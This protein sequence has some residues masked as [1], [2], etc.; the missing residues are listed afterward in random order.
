MF[1]LKATA[2]FQLLFIYIKIT[3]YAITK[4]LFKKSITWAIS[5]L[6]FEKK[7]TL[8]IHYKEVTFEKNNSFRCV[9]VTFQSNFTHCCRRGI[10]ILPILSYERRRCCLSPGV[11]LFLVQSTSDM[12]SPE[13]TL[14]MAGAPPPPQSMHDS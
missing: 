3:L 6:L 11:L 2:N 8:Y 5:K 7:L 10:P 13:N 1:F 12:K 14:S 4:I 9:E